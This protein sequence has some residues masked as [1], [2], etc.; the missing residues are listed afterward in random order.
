[1]TSN[2]RSGMEV[3]M[4]LTYKRMKKFNDCR[5]ILNIIF[6]RIMNDLHLVKFGRSN[7]NPEFAHTIPQYK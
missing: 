7:Y 5:N 4:T 2:L 6:K 1:M 3:E